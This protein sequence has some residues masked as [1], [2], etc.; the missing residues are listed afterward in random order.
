MSYA[1]DVNVLL[2]ASDRQSPFHRRA[3]EFLGD[4][5]SRAEVFYVAW[6]TAMAYLRI[7]THPAVFEAPLP[8]EEAMRNIEA[9]LRLPHARFLGEEEGFWDAYRRAT[10]GL[11]V[12]GNLVP[13]AHVAALLFQHGVRRFYTRDADFRRFAFL[14]VRDPFS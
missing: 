9:L 10:D 2:Y 11:T 5:S 14:D 12:R 4:C 6:P 1:F 7:A 13:D 3:V 8:P